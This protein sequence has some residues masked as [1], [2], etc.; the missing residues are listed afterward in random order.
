MKIRTFLPYLFLTFSFLLFTCLLYAQ[1]EVLPDTVDV[2]EEF[3][4][5]NKDSLNYFEEGTWQYSNAQAYGP[6]SR[7]AYVNQHPKACAHFFI[8]LPKSGV[9]ELFEIV[10]ATANAS[11]HGVYVLSISNVVVDSLVLNQNVG[12]GNWVSLGRHYLPGGHKIEIK[13]VDTGEGTQ[14]L[15]LRADAIKIALEEELIEVVIEEE[16]PEEIPIEEEVIEEEIPEEELIEEEIILEEPEEVPEEVVEEEPIEEVT[17]GHD[18]V[19]GASFGGMIPI[20]QNIKDVFN[21]GIPFTLQAKVPELVELSGM[22]VGAGLELGYYMASAETSDDLSGIP[23]LIFGDLNLSNL[24]PVSENMSLGIELAVGLHLQTRG[25]DSFTYLGVTP[26]IVFGY[27]VMEGLNVVAKLRPSEI[28][29][30]DEDFGGTQEWIGLRIGVNY[31]L[32]ILLPF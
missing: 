3:I 31:T 13:V 25:D 23:I 19:V 2:E 6:T 14:G 30:S 15:V 24:I 21:M 22:S 20:G 32:P 10:P 18:L 12:S 4:I 9:Y 5:D 29:S 1:E 27:E 7:Y 17:L 28:L 26:G 16:I 8:T 11:D